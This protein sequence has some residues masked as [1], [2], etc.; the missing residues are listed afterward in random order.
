MSHTPSSASVCG[1]GLETS[2]EVLEVETSPY[3]LLIVFGLDESATLI[4]C[5]AD[6]GDMAIMVIIKDLEL[7]SP[8]SSDRIAFPLLVVCSALDHSGQ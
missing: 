3:S 8:A 5:A 1:T 2:N 4:V 7:C 6:L